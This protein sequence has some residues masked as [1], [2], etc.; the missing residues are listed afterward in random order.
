MFA[1]TGVSGV[2]EYRIEAGS[3]TGASDLA[4]FDTRSAQTTYLAV[5]LGD[6]VYY[7]RVRG[8]NG[9]S[10]GDPS[11]EVVLTVGATSCADPPVVLQELR[12]TQGRPCQ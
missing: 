5:G 3:R 12:A 7:V 8:L 6:G 2:T 10:A 11:N 4:V 1:W 9:K